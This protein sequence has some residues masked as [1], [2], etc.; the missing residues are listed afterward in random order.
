MAEG[1]E[2]RK[3]EKLDDEAN[4][5]QGEKENAAPRRERR[6]VR[7]NDAPAVE[8]AAEAPAAETPAAE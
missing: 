6:R 8:A 5:A 3:A 4:N 7:R 2:E 1:L